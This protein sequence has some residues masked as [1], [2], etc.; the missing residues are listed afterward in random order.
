MT[1]VRRE[2]LIP[3]PVRGRL[4]AAW[5]NLKAM[6]ERQQKIQF[7]EKTLLA[8]LLNEFQAGFAFIANHPYYFLLP[9]IF[10]LVIW[11]GPR[12]SLEK[13]LTKPLSKFFAEA[14]APLPFEFRISYQPVVNLL[15]RSL[16]STNLMGALSFLPGSIPY[17]FAGRLPDAAPVTSIQ[18]YDVPDLSGF[19]IGFVLL[20]L[21]GYLVGVFYYVTMTQR[22]LN[23][24]KLPLSGF[25]HLAFKLFVVILI[26][27][28]VAIGFAVPISLGL[29]LLSRLGDMAA[30]LFMFA[31][32]ILILR[33]VYPF[34]F[35]PAGIFAGLK[36]R[37]A[38]LVSR[39]FTKMD[40][41]ANV[42]FCLVYFAIYAGLRQIWRIPA[43]NSWMTLIGVLGSAFVT[44]SLF[45]AYIIRYQ[46]QL[47]NTIVLTQLLSGITSREEMNGKQSSEQ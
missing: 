45:A 25:F 37:D 42:N 8:T 43:S 15:I 36:I 44:T 22:L 47:H 39:N 9:I 12:V 29:M 4:T 21:V 24:P 41:I 19:F 18:T 26:G 31:V 14:L 27:A 23:A 32:A 46:T 34:L 5:Y 6:D 2:R 10:D 35:V 40:P 28:A 38:V 13:A 30:A 17:L 7:G 33:A 11:F 3:S 1:A 20:A 16:K